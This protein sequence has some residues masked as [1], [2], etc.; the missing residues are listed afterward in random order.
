MNIE[1]AAAAKRDLNNLRDSEQEQVSNILEDLRSA[2]VESASPHRLGW[3]RRVE[4]SERVV[5]IVFRCKA[6]IDEVRILVIGE[7][8]DVEEC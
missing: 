6:E 5:S 4:C 2:P 8:S 7:K 1:L 3:V